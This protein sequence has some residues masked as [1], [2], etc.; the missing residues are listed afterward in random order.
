MS[1]YPNL[2]KSA[3][4]CVAGD[5]SGSWTKSEA[6]RPVASNAQRRTVNEPHQ[7]DGV[8][9]GPERGSVAPVAGMHRALAPVCG[10]HSRKMR[11]AHSS[12]A[13]TAIKPGRFFLSVQRNPSVCSDGCRAPAPHIFDHSVDFPDARKGNR[14]FFVGVSD[15]SVLIERESQLQSIALPRRTAEFS[16]P[17][18]LRH[19]GVR[20]PCRRGPARLQ[21]EIRS[22]P[23]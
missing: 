17:A 1:V 6:Q 23:R 21:D 5:K 18:S 13:T 8:R 10:T 14:S 16:G 11:R 3:V 22:R 4:K 12:P 20:E 9:E 19:C 2:E 15:R 7:V